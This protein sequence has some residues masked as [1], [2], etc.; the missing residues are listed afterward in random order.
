MVVLVL[1]IVR[2]ADRVFAETANVQNKNISESF[3]DCQIEKKSIEKDLNLERKQK[4]SENAD[5]ELL[6]EDN[7]ALKVL[8][9]LATLLVVI[10]VIWIALGSG[11]GDKLKGMRL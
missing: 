11:L 9:L 10:I 5:M 2:V 8:A 7:E 1:L 4:T 3:R 6:E